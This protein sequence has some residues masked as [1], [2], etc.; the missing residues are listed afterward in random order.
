[1]KDRSPGTVAIECPGCQHRFCYHCLQEAIP[2]DQSGP[3][4]IVCEG[5]TVHRPPCAGDFNRYIP[6]KGCVALVPRNYELTV[7]GC[8]AHL[9]WLV[10]NPSLPNGCRACGC[11]MHRTTACAEVVHCGLRQ[12]TVCGMSGL[13]F[14]THLIDHWHGEGRLGTCSHVAVE[15]E[16][17]KSTAA[18]LKKFYSCVPML[19]G[20]LGHV[21]DK[22]I[23]DLKAG[24]CTLALPS[25]GAKCTGRVAC[26]SECKAI[27][28]VH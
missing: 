16:T 15:G 14:E 20:F 7:A 8:L 1:M 12:C 25:C 3:N 4:G 13:E 5:C 10:E 24:I 6:K 26:R 2:T 11:P 9:K 19:G 28:V 18:A 17:P 23:A 21:P 22:C 27:H